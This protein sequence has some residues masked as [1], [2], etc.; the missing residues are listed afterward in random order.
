MRSGGAAPGPGG[1]RH[2][3]WELPPPL[4]EALPEL[5]QHQRERPAPGEAHTNQYPVINRQPNDGP[6]GDGRGAR[7]PRPR[8]HPPGRRRQRE[9]G[10]GGAPGGEQGER[11]GERAAPGEEGPGAGWGGRGE[12]AGLAAGAL[13]FGC[14]RDYPSPERPAGR[15]GTER[16][17]GVGRRGQRLPGRAR[18]EPYE[19]GAPAPR[20]A[21]GGKPQRASASPGRRP[22]LI[23][24]RRRP[25]KG[26]RGAALAS[27]RRRLPP[28][29]CRTAPLPAA[30]SLGWCPL[31]C[32]ME[33]A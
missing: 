10:D 17:A 8:T 31:G 9:D 7:Q 19:S 32:G 4:R 5:Q 3:W 27:R 18:G 21:Q 29:L 14:E 30:A 13:W 12:R 33:S 25:W 16:A 28:L 15:G 22:R 6:A 2:V 23:I 24:P 20:G 26:P 11:G 1:S